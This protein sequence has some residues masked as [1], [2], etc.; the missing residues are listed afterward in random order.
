MNE[1]KFAEF[2]AVMAGIFGHKWSSQYGEDPTSITARVWNDGLA[3]LSL[4]QIANGIKHYKNVSITAVWP[5]SLPEF[6]CNALDIPSLAQARYN[7]TQR[8]TDG[9]TRMVFSKIDTY[10]LARADQRLADQIIREAY[11]VAVF[12]VMNGDLLPEPVALIEQVKPE[13]VPAKP[14]TVAQFKAEIASL[15]GAV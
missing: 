13:F 5:P 2:F 6:R 15:V 3:S 1:Q 9:F 12:A 11:E 10:L 14:E 8:H 7:V 4:K